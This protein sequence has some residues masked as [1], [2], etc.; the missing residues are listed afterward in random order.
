MNRRNFMGSLTAAAA[1]PKVSAVSAP[2][3][4]SSVIQ[5][6]LEAL[7]V[8]GR[9][10]GGTF[11]DGVSRVGYSAADIAGRK[12]VMDLMR[13]AGAIVRIDAAGNIFASRPG[14]QPS[15]PPVLFGSHIDSVP[16]G[17]NFDGDLGS[18][19]AI[20]TLQ[21]LKD[22]GIVTRHPLTAVVWACEEASFAGASL[23]G[24]RLA[25][26]KAAPDELNIV[27]RGMTKA[28]AI[29]RIGGDPANLEK[30]L[31]APRA[32]H[33][34]VELHIEQGGNLAREGLPVGVVDGIVSI[35]HYDVT[36]T[37]FANH[38]GTTP[39][40][41][42]QDALVAASMLTLAV[43]E[44][45]NAE[46][47]PQVGTVGHL[48]VLPNATNVIPGE[49][50]LTVEL[51]DLSSAKLQRLGAKIQQRATAIA[52][53]TKTRITMT[54]GSHS[55]SASAAPEVQ[56]AIESAAGRLRLE[57][58]HLPS[59]AGHDAQMAAT[60]MPMGMIFVPSIGGISHS[61]KELTLWQDCANG[62]NMLL[63]TVLDLACPGKTC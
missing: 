44:I 42:R 53:E 14:S 22:S 58:R 29:R 48:E 52:A 25:A 60:L 36:I 12:F 59:G 20:Q 57:S 23:N 39:M 21:L 34:Y 26:G 33:A 7:S 32:Y 27:S 51:R 31:I 50:R 41:D 46:P 5:A 3:I 37:G 63:E 2:R 49:V 40:P 19:A 28:E 56:R 11:Q 8:F 1:L 13:N 54:R 24:S 15:L 16:S 18:L 43:R 55:E 30:A 45:V 38:A 17:G 47:G 4:S 35:D 10:A 9:P 61:P 6:R 62:A